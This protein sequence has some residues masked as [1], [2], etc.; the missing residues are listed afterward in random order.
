MMMNLLKNVISIA[1]IFFFLSTISAHGEGELPLKGRILTIDECIRLALRFHPSIRAGTANVNALKAKVQASISAYYP[2]VNITS[3]YTTSTYNF[4]ASGG[5]VKST[6]HSMTF[7]DIFSTGPSLTH[8]IYDFGRTSNTVKMNRENLKVSEEELAQIKQMVIFNVKQSYFGVLQA[9][10]LVDVAKEMVS[11]SRQHLEQARAFYKA[12]TRPKIDVTKAEVDLANAEL[13]LIRANNNLQVSRI[14][15]NNSMGIDEYMEFEIEDSLEFKPVDI[16]IREIIESSYLRR[17]EILQLKAKQ[18]SQE[19]ALEAARATYFPILSGIASYLLKG[20]RI[21]EYYW[22]W[23]FGLTLTIPIF[24]GFS[25]SAQVAEALSV[26]RNLRAQEENLKLALRLEAEQAYLSLKEAE[27]R[28]RVTQKNLSQ[29]Q[30]N[31]ELA[32]GR[33]QV[34][35]GSPLEVT[36]AEVMLANAKASY[37]QALY[38]YKIAEARI[39]KAMGKMP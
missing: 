8:T 5:E 9:I 35:V 11:Q 4:I 32:R 23:S 22:D 6:G 17:P 27:E 33:Y 13:G 26:L 12:G 16:T 30:E 29:A 18:R 19:A 37:I 15:L 21:D 2:Q 7:F 36:D 38:D 24:S 25:S 3:N 1:L 39:D 10:R 31:F 20:T 14:A 28:L 34:G